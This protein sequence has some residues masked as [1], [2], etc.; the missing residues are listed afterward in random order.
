M[1]RQILC[2]VSLLCLQRNGETK[3]KV[4]NILAL[5]AMEWKEGKKSLCFLVL[6]HILE[7]T[8]KLKS[9]VPLTLFILVSCKTWQ[10]L[11]YCENAGTLCFK[12]MFGKVFLN[13]FKILIQLQLIG[14][15]VR[16]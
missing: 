8:E 15:W 16:V 10:Y 14:V 7:F 12:K 6:P 13:I 4:L 11:L 3:E 5:F 2:G 1:I 9:L